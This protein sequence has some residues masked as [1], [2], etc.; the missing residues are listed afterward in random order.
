MQLTSNQSFNPSPF[1]PPAYPWIGTANEWTL[2]FIGHKDA[3]ILRAPYDSRYYVGQKS[4]KHTERHYIP[5]A[6]SVT[7]TQ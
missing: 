2:L 7:L 5:L 4:T 1:L 3:V 6:G